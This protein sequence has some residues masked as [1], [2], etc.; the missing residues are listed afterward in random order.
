VGGAAFLWHSN[1][2]K[3]KR[4]AWAL[5]GLLAGALLLV[6]TR[7][8]EEEPTFQEKRLSEWLD[9][10][11]WTTR[12]PEATPEVR[13]AGIAIREIG[14]NGLPWLLR[15]VSYEDP[16]WLKQVAR[17][18]SRM[19]AAFQ[20]RF[21]YEQLGRYDARGWKAVSALGLLG[22]QAAP[23]LP[24]LERFAGDTNSPDRAF[25]AKVCLEL[26]RRS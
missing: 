24:S 25:R 13:R 18:S 6:A 8:R 3:P 16:D 12:V 9:R 7:K 19:P 15:W 1:G 26:L 23:A 4:V 21:L 11:G 22:D 2:V 20:S 5:L 17:S 10:Y 14:T